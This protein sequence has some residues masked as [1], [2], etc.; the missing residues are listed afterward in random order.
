[1]STFR[2]SCLGMESFGLP[3]VHQ[4]AVL[5][6]KDEVTLPNTLVLPRWIVLLSPLFLVGTIP[7]SPWY[8]LY[9]S[10]HLPRSDPISWSKAA[11]SGIIR[12]R[13]ATETGDARS[14]YRARVSALMHHSKRFVKVACLREDNFKLYTEM[15]LKHTLELEGLKGLSYEGALDGELPSVS[16][17]HDPGVRDPKRVR[18]KGTAAANRSCNGKSSKVPKKRRCSLCGLLGHWRT[19]CPKSTVPTPPF[20]NRDAGHSAEVRASNHEQ[21]SIRG[22]VELPDNPSSAWLRVDE[23]AE[24]GL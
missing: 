19:R 4:L 1:M 15:V 6:E 23:I 12:D 17:S 10:V 3:C 7:T 11:K 9:D 5:L 20:C 16:R 18:T 8:Y 13:L 2:C 22:H 24:L 14:M 21:S